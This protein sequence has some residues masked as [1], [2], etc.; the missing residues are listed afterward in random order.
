MTSRA[1][2]IDHLV[3]AWHDLAAARAQYRRF[4]FTLT[5]EARHPFGTGNS[6]AQLQ[7]SFLELLA[8]V[9]PD[10]LVPM[11][12]SR[13][14]FGAY[15]ADFLARREGLSMVV[16][17]SDDAD[18]DNAAWAARGLATYEPLHFSR[19]ARLPDG[20]A[21][22]VAFSL[23]FAVDPAMPEAAFFVCQ[24]HN[25]EAFWQPQYQRHDNGARAIVGVT[26]RAE[27]PEAHRRF[28]EALVSPEAVQGVEGG[29]SV[30]L[31]GGRIEVLTAAALRQRFACDL[32]GVAAMGPAFVAT[33]LAVEDLARLR[34]RLESESVAFGSRDG[35]I[36]IAP[37]EAGGVLLEFVAV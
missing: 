37:E 5:P 26:L 2:A 1:P 4:G 20:G 8:V 19:E 30:A 23:A 6:L 22:T 11:A 18:A 13:F 7:G 35:A 34:S 28:F 3:L 32:S 10:K 29:F 25:P 15:N 33:T 36:E 12:G 21:A 31:E 24:Q 27:A 9:E 14:S 17:T 16:L